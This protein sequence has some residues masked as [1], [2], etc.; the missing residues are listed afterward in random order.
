MPV[1]ISVPKKLLTEPTRDV[2][3][4]TI[5]A[6]TS[7]AGS[8]GETITVDIQTPDGE[9]VQLTFGA[10]TAP[11]SK[12]GQFLTALI[13]LVRVPVEEL[14]D[15]LEGVWFEF[16]RQKIRFGRGQDVREVDV[17]LPMRIVESVELSLQPADE[18]IL[19]HWPQEVLVTDSTALVLWAAA[20]AATDPSFQAVIE[21]ITQQPDYIAYLAARGAITQQPDGRWVPAAG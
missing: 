6:V 17:W 12:W 18:F 10:S 4:G 15:A 2:L 5:I 14:G 9:I 11:N 21:H 13:N 8:F 20:N 3:V 16:S 7:G 1:T 19:S